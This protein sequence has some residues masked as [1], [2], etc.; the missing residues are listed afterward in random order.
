MLSE[1]SQELEA[2]LTSL[3]EEKQKSAS[4]NYELEVERD[5]LARLLSELEKE[6]QKLSDEERLVIG[7]ARDRIVREAA[8]LHKEIRHAAAELRREKSASALEQA[9][10]TLYNTRDRISSGTW[11][12][13]TIPLT[14]TGSD[15][16]CIG[17]TVRLKDVGLT[18]TVL[19]ISE[20]L[21]EIEV[22]K[23]R[24]K[25]RIGLDSVIKASPTSEMT[26]SS[27]KKQPD[28]KTVSLELDLRGKRADEV[29]IAL[30][31]YLSD[32]VHANLPEVRIIHGIGTGTVRSIVRE[33]LASHPL[34]KS[35]RSGEQGEGGDGTTLIN[36]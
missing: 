30:D 23:G 20:E 21:Q 28:L 11:S 2:T 19:S 15:N 12:S 31:G 32:A 13:D 3:M 25:L 8:E 27:V 24:T 33:F 6:K 26:T 10:Q 7:E 16:I 34:V 9:R 29:E 36:F 18:A 35:F 1:G 5:R 17:D 22:Q 4:L 14:P